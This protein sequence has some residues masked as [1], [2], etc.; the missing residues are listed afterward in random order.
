MNTRCQEILDRLVEATTGSV[1]PAARAGLAEHLTTC[2]ECRVES[3]RI[4]A[5]AALLRAGREAVAPPGYWAEFNAR[6]TARLAE[7][8]RTVSDRLRRWVRNPRPAWSTAAVTAA[9]AVAVA[10]A[11]NIAPVRQASDPATERARGLVTE[12]MTTTLPSLDDLL[13]TWR[14]GL[15]PET[16]APN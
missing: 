10:V 2:P 13:K 16:P 3:A 1:P 15:N 9:A 12:T 5:T 7:E 4:E 11:V 8:P 14:A 6:L